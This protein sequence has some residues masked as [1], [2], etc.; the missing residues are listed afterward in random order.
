MKETEKNQSPDRLLIGVLGNQSSGK[1]H[2]WNDL[3]GKTVQRGKH[4]RPL[5]L[6]PGECVEIF[7]VSGSFEERG[8]YA[9]DI[10]ANQVCRIVLCSLQY[11]EEVNST[12]DYFESNDFFLYVQW[13]NP[14]RC[15][16]SEQSDDLKIVEKILSVP[17]LVSIRNG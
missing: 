12:L 9:G 14:G 15:D 3:F 1:S 16:A 5:T 10:L 7:L 8:E 13:L 2:T 6:R 4:P 11:S 17:S